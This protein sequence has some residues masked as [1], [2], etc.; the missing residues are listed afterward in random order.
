MHWWCPIFKE[1]QLQLDCNTW[2][3]SSSQAPSPIPVPVHW[4][5]FALKKEIVDLLSNN[6]PLFSTGTVKSAHK[7]KV[8]LWFTVV[9]TVSN[10]ALHAFIRA[11]QF[12]H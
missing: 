2:E 5:D 10:A 8:P 7:V 4:G 11:F 9:K 6:Y 1:A 3:G 12:L